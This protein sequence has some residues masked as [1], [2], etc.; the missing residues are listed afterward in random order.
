[1]V[2]VQMQVFVHRVRF[3][4]YRGLCSW[5]NDCFLRLD[6]IIGG[7]DNRSVSC[8]PFGLRVSNIIVLEMVCDLPKFNLLT[9]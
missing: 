7:L 5:V 8:L 4:A 2:V 9:D 6:I 3:I 1:M